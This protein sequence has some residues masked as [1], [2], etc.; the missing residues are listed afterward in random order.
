MTEAT[1][2]LARLEREARGLEREGHYHEA[3][4]LRTTIYTIRVLMKPP[5]LLPP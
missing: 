2:R 1:D 5:D 4:I 3:G